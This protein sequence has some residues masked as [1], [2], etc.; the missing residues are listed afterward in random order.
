M[1]K[2]TV[3]GLAAHKLRLALT[4]TSILLGI[5]FLAGTF[6]LADTT[7]VAFDQLFGKISSG[8]DV[9]ARQ[10]AA[11]AADSGATHAPTPASV[12]AT[13]QS[14]P[15]V[16]V[17]EGD[18]SGYALMTD[19]K[20]KAIIPSLGGQTMGLTMPADER[21]R[22]DVDFR[23]GH[24][25]S[26]PSEVV[27]DA[28]SAIDHHLHVGDTI[29]VLFHGPTRTYTVVGIVD[30]GGKTDLGGN[31][32]AYFDV[33]TAQAAMGSAGHYD[34]IDV[35]A[36]PG[37]SQNELARRINATLPARTEA[38]TRTQIQ[39]EFSDMISK[40][41]GFFTILLS[42]F[43][44]VALFVGSFIIW[45]TFSMIVSQRSRE[46]ALLRA[47]GATRG[48]V[49]R[50]I[51]TEALL[52]GL[53]ASALG[54]LAGV[55]VAKG[56]AAL[57][58]AIG[59]SLPATS[60]QIEPRTIWVSLI[61]GTVVT[62]VAALVPARRATKVLPVEA[63]RDATPGA[64]APSKRRAVFGSALGLG[65]AAALFAGLFGD[66]PAILIAVGAVGVMLAVT[67][68]APLVARGMAAVIGWP[69]RAL[70]VPGN[71][72]RQN[73]MRNPRRTASTASALMIGLTLVVSVG[74][75]ASSLK[76]SFGGVLR[77][78]TN[79]D[80]FVT[81]TSDG[82]AGFSTDVAKAV[83]R[84][85]G[86]AAVS[87]TGFGAARFA[88][89]DSDYTSIDPATA[90]Q[91][92][93]LDLSAGHA[94]ALGTDGVLVR[95]ATAQ[96][97]GWKVGSTVPAEFASTGRHALHV[98]GIFDRTGGYVDGEYVISLATQAA[99]DGTRL[100]TSALVLLAKG[101]DASAVH[102]GIKAALRDH[103]DAKVQT[104]KEYEK[105]ASGQV[106]KLLAFVTVM[107]LLA[108]A[109]ALL[110]IVNTLALSVFERTREL[111]LLRAVGMTRNQ[112]RSMVRYESVVISLIG[113]V[114]GAVLGIAVGMALAQSLKGEGVTQV[115]VPLVQV[116]LYV[117]AAAI[118]GVIAAIGPARSAAGVDVLRAVVVE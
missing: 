53:G 35:S 54:L 60:S 104:P 33:A 20:G 75:F 49:R 10:E 48:Q 92:F 118:A 47:V 73:A 110:G 21:L 81:R 38:V 105:S 50:S 77:G 98:V 12:L 22:G 40:G 2:T 88:G 82:S 114:V 6:I 100:D 37:V 61:T 84:V 55:G 78:S 25:P 34:Q 95:K 107:L 71:L 7:K 41:L 79:A 101:V 43:A 94:T 28:R 109:I 58:G 13:V 116:L 26:G 16:R 90:E 39:H 15:G 69:L 59:F 99:F 96:E 4:T 29:K 64:S 5:A 89:D 115:S 52:I 45:N 103:P 117:V 87:E 1:F 85:P 74:V 72:A 62:V 56:L 106:D 80:L 36:D 91:A 32:T 46:I 9:V 111:G 83:A 57:M 67:T 86:V 63:L 65:G 17:A 30:F 14:V 93:N 24:A 3:R 70:G 27:M 23:S 42:V 68:L 76:G 19:T 108:V 8:T 97:H 11:F 51:L 18:V 66:A 102:A 113:A 112:V 31:T 44:G